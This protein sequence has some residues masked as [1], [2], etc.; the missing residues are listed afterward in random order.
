MESAAPTTMRVRSGSTLDVRIGVLCLQLP[1][2]IGV[3]LPRLFTLQPEH[4]Q[5]KLAAVEAHLLA[6]S[7]EV[8]AP[9][10]VKHAVAR[11]FNSLGLPAQY[12]VETQVPTIAKHVESLQGVC[13]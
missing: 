3:S 4:L 8:W 11:Y 2:H 13:S 7:P 1:F 10:A 5:Q 6:R 12:F 9:E